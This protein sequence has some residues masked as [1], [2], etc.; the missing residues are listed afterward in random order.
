MD[1]LDK[2]FERNPDF[3]A[4][5]IVDEIVLVP[6]RGNVGDLASIYTLNP[7]GAFVWERL[8]GARTVAEVVGDVT[9]EFDVDTETATKD[10]VELLEELGKIETIACRQPAGE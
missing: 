8:D 9:A 3:V 6:V 10:V 1:Y 4:R 2:V 7:V 5:K